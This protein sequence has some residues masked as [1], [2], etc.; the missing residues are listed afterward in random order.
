[1]T[2]TKSYKAINTVPT[3]KR[4]FI[5]SKCLFHGGGSFLLN[6]TLF[7]SLNDLMDQNHGP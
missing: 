5:T 2:N 7:M 4:V 6:F 3:A 1:M